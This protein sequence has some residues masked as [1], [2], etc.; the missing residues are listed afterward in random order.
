[1]V[2]T[3]KEKKIDTVLID[4]DGTLMDTNDL[5]INSWMH[6]IKRYTGKEGNIEE[7][8]RSFGETIA[9][10]MP[11]LIPGVPFQDALDEYRKFQLDNYLEN[12]KPFDGV[13]E[14]LETLKEKGYKIAMVTSRLERSTNVGLEHFDLD[15]YFEVV[16]TADNCK[17][18]KP[19][20]LPL[21]MAM[22]ALGS[23]PENTIMIGDTKHDIEA[24][25]AA[26]VT[27]VLVDY[28]VA[29]PHERRN[30]VEKPDYII[31]QFADILTLVGV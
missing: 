13:S 29:L 17:E 6:A 7:V 1:M 26:G 21:L 23:S 3:I 31:E 2:E 20:P 16:I 5:I 14:T 25:K 8:T 28:S 19:S 15:K 10:S 18:H 4:F 9:Q 30:E 27:S 24:A 12:I 11:R 22:E